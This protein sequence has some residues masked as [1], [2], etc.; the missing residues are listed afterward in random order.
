LGAWKCKTNHGG[1]S[2]LNG[3]FVAIAS[4]NDFT[5]WEG[6]EHMSE[7]KLHTSNP[8][9][10]AFPIFANLLS[11]I[12][13]HKDYEAWYYSNF[14]QL[15]ASPK[16]HTLTFYGCCAYIDQCPLIINHSMD[17]WIIDEKWNGNIVSFLIEAINKNTYIYLFIDEAMISNSSFSKKV[18][19]FTHD[20]M[21][22]G[23]NLN[24]REFYIA[25]NFAFGKYIESTCTFDEM[26]FAY[27]NTDLS[28]D[29]FHGVRMLRLNSNGSYKLGTNYI[30]EQLS[31]YL[32]ST[33][34][35]IKTGDFIH[36]EHCFGLSVYE[37]L[38][39][40][41]AELLN[42]GELKL[43]IRPFHFFLEHKKCMLERINFLDKNNIFT[44]RG[45]L[46]ELKKTYQD[47]CNKALI[48]RSTFLKYMI[49]N[50][51]VYLPR[52]ISDLTDMQTREREAISYLIES[53]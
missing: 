23:F 35:A 31:D 46:D 8:S 41:L 32:H 20:V 16:S 48:H 2:G 28:K 5:G 50:A 39:D 19:T 13:A 25:G 52:I 44:S 45:K 14:I 10:Y 29:W 4:I 47:I 15:S 40:Y 3:T 37:V 22:T 17:R 53:I 30:K 7:V 9:I 38:R 1:R 34:S 42:N 24:R 11:I 27:D 36:N 6:A 33:N 49:N 43:S 12:S 18:I 21:I 26:Q 51:P